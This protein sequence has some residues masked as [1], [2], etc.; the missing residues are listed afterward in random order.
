MGERLAAAEAGVGRAEADRAGWRR[1]RGQLQVAL[2]RVEIGG[3]V[4]AERIAAA[5]LTEI[6]PQLA[7]LGKRLDGVEV[8]QATLREDLSNLRGADPPVKAAD[9]RMVGQADSKLAT[10]VAIIER[11]VR[12]LTEDVAGTGGNEEWG[13][14]RDVHASRLMMRRCR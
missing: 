12:G 7:K 8:A 5:M 1:V 10:R 11:D 3:A 2:A 6:G 14:R 9:L 4:S 13:G